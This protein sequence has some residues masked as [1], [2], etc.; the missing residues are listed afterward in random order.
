MHH[1]VRA[2]HRRWRQL[3]YMSWL[4]A[5]NA[6]HAQW[7]QPTSASGH[8][9]HAYTTME[10]TVALAG[11]TAQTFCR[12]H[13]RMRWR[14]TRAMLR[15][16]RQPQQGRALGRKAGSGHEVKSLSIDD[17][18]SGTLM[19]WHTTWSVDPN[20]NNKMSSE[21]SF[22]VPATLQQTHSKTEPGGG[23]SSRAAALK[24]A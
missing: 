24:R 11:L 4:T 2:A 16:Q 5:K 8:H 19:R 10:P 9:G 20:G 1:R 22:L 13:D 14:C 3:L 21:S 23:L 17:R 15:A 6:A 18:A 12:A 7:T